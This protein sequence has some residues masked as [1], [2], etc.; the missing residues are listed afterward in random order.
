MGE[1]NGQD[2][3]DED[4]VAYVES[5]VGYGFAEDQ[6]VEALEKYDYNTERAINY[7]LDSKSKSSSKQ[8]KASS[9]PS[10]QQPKQLKPAQFT[11]KAP[12]NVPKPAAAPGQAKGKVTT[13]QFFTSFFFFFES[14]YGKGQ[15]WYSF[16]VFAFIFFFGLI[17]STN[18]HSFY[19]SFSILFRIIA[20]IF[21]CKQFSDN[22]FVFTIIN[23]IG[24]LTK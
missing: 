4:P 12:L 22:D 18:Q 14:V 2:E 21:R 3:S 5:V 23:F 8:Q 20:I 10:K 13:F 1:G 9:S 6:I 15:C 16:F 7:L 11:P 17:G 19:F 24:T